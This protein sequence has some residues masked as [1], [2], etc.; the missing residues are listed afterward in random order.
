MTP[1]ERATAREMGLRHYY[2]PTLKERFLAWFYQ[3]LP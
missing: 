2:Q 1:F 3:W